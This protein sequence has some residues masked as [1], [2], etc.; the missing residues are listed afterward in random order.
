[1]D[2]TLR[3]LKNEEFPFLYQLMQQSFPPSEFRSYEG[4]YSL[5]GYPNYQ[6]LV[7]ESEGVIQAF[8]AE[9]LFDTF[10]YV[11]HFAVNPS[12]RG[13]GLG[14]NILR[15]YLSTT[16]LPVVIEVEAADTVEAKRRIAFYE[17][18]CF[19][20]SDIEYLQPHLQYSPHDVLLRL[21]VHP[22]DVTKEELLL[23]KECIFDGVYRKDYLG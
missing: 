20:Q 21:M 15:S 3:L 1:M 7:A 22:V 2:A 14:S 10:H 11:E 6:V 4:E 12:S 8:I 5:F 18:L 19:K 16:K 13:K 17:R 23:M 9:W